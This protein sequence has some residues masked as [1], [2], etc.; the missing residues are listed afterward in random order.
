MI[1][2][3]NKQTKKMFQTSDLMGKNTAE[4]LHYVTRATVAGCHQ[5]S[6]IFGKKKEKNFI[7]FSGCKAVIL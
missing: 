1:I 5:C 6:V 4:N 7:F 2:K 3:K